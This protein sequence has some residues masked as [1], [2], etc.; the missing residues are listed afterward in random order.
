[1]FSYDVVVNHYICKILNIFHRIEEAFSVFLQ[2]FLRCK[3]RVNDLLLYLYLFEQ[4]TTTTT[5][6]TTTAT[7]AKTTTTT[8]A[9]TTTTTITIAATTTATTT[10]ETTT[11][12]A[13]TTTCWLQ[14]VC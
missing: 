9:T 4:I 13:T 7:T 11:T 12:T 3:R 10:S 8:T 5:T 2:K 14:Y 1:M 6:T